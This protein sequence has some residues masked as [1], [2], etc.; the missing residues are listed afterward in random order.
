MAE[1]LAAYTTPRQFAEGLRYLLDGIE[2]RAVRPQQG[3][4]GPGPSPTSDDR[5]D[6][7]GD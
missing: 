2:H 4:A 7:E 6:H 1:Q 5:D 3:R